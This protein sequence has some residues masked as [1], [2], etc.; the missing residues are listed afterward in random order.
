MLDRQDVIPVQTLSA[1]DRSL[2]N[3]LTGVSLDIF[4][5]RKNCLCLAFREELELDKLFFKLVQL[6][7]HLS[8]LC[9]K[10]RR[11][12]HNSAYFPVHLRTVVHAPIKQG[13]F[14]NFLN[15]IFS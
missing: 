12:H 9:I 14:K 15:D 13:I 2:R 7:S 4:P 8:L 3:Q 6:Y 10:Y 5:K 11:L 1:H